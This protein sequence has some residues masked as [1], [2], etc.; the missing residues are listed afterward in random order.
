MRD[1]VITPLGHSYERAALEEHLKR[2]PTD[3]L[4]NS[5]L[6]LDDVR[7]NRGLREAI[8]SYRIEKGL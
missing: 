2:S 8:D 5:P 6:N 1:P 3:P 7:P 4:T